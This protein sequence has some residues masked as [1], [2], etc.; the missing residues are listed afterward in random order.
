MPEPEVAKTQKAANAGGHEFYGAVEE[1]VAVQ[2]AMGRCKCCDCYLYARD[3]E[4]PPDN[5]EFCSMYC[6]D[7]YY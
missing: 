1:M 5:S 7:N 6:E 4:N 2:E 3:E